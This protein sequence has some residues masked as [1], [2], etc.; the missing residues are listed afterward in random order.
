MK[1]RILIFYCFLF[2]SCSV[3]FIE[4]TVYKPVEVDYNY[5]P[6]NRS[7]DDDD[8]TYLLNP[9]EIGNS[10]LET[11]SN[12]EYDVAFFKNKYGVML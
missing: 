7:L 2:L 1:F 3:F 8:K 12:L 10:K 6:F 5:Q 4:G 9:T 11:G